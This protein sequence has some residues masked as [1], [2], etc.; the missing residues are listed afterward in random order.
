MEKFF[1]LGDGITILTPAEQKK[2]VG[3]MDISLRCRGYINLKC[4]NDEDCPSSCFCNSVYFMCID[5][6]G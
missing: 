1:S 4:N 2:I 3:G 6:K 5:K